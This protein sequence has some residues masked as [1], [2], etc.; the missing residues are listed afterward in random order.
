MNGLLICSLIALMAV[1][2]ASFGL[3]V[4]VLIGFESKMRAVAHYFSD[5]HWDDEVLLEIRRIVISLLEPSIGL[6][7]KEFDLDAAISK[8]EGHDDCANIRQLLSKLLL[9]AKFAKAD[10]LEVSDVEQFVKSVYQFHV[11]VG[12]RADQLK[13]LLAPAIANLKGR[14]LYSEK[15]GSIELVEPKSRVDDLL[16]WPL[17]PGLRVQQP[18]GFIIRGE[19]GDVLSRAKVRCC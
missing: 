14:K 7:S 12:L 8:V 11:E 16:M 19:S 3:T 4:R 1:S 5:Q 15:I 18:Y 13:K 9:T 6:S 10:V 2:L 17:N